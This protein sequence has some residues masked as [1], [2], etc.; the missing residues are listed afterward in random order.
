[1]NNSK[2]LIN[3]A[4]PAKKRTSSISSKKS[5]SNKGQS[6]S[7]RSLVKKGQAA[8]KVTASVA[9]LAAASTSQKENNSPT[10]SPKKTE[11]QKL[12]SRRGS[13]V[14]SSTIQKAPFSN[15]SKQV[16]LR[17]VNC[18][19]ITSHKVPKIK[20]FQVKKASLSDSDFEDD[21]FMQRL[22]RDY[23]H[24]MQRSSLSTSPRRYASA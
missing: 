6:A 4:P 8:T 18:E 2:L 20:G 23:P 19:R 5:K 11:A 16:H 24:V 13:F 9:A 1:M 22:K 12:G 7:S 10:K 21:P 15:S 3:G 14:L 17:V